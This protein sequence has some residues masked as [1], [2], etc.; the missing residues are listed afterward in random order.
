MLQRPKLFVGMFPQL[1]CS[2]HWAIYHLLQSDI[3]QEYTR[4]V[5]MLNDS[6]S[7]RAGLCQIICSPCI[8]KNVSDI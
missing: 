1:L 4:F 8:K 5:S 7:N 3:Q 6:I 2:I